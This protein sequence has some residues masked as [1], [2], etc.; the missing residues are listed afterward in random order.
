MSAIWQVALG[1]TLALAVALA[2]YKARALNASGAWAAWLVGGLTFGLG[3]LWAALCLMVFFVSA[4]LWSRYGRARKRRLASVAAKG[5][6]R[7]AAQVLANGGA[8]ALLAAAFGL[9]GDLGFFL[10]AAGALAAANADTWSTELG[11]LARAWPRLI[12]SGQRV[13]PGTS[14]GVTW[15]GWLAALGGSAAIAL[16]ALP[17]L[18]SA[19]AALAVLAG[20]VGGA[21]VDSLL[22]AT[23]QASY[24]CPACAKATE[25][26]PRHR[27]GAATQYQRGW[28]WMNNDAVNLLATLSGALLAMALGW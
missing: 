21:L 13:E 16:A 1:I 19:G 12:T 4:S 28:R 2:A 6:R 18:R 10:G 20:G 17:Q 11:V 24:W 27:C 3:G 8:A 9:R 22:G 15:Q 7:D 5:G 14:G 23:L 25:H 26:H